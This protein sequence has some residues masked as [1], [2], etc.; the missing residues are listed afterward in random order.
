MVSQKPD[1]HQI[2]D[3]LKNLSSE[4]WIRRDE[5]RLWPR[6]LFHYTD[7]RNAV[8]ILNDGYLYS[9]KYV[10]ENEKLRVSSGSWDV[11]DRTDPYFKTCAR[12]YFRP[13]TP[14][15]F[16]VEGIRSNKTLSGAK[17]KDAHCPVMVFFLFDA[18]EV[19]SRVDCE[20][21]DGNLSS[22]IAK[23]FSNADDLRKLP[24]KIIYH[25]GSLDLTRSDRA[26]IIIRRNAEVI[27]KD[28][29]SLS[30]L[31]YIYCRSAAEKDTLLNLLSDDIRKTYQPK[32]VSTTRSLL[33]FREHTFLENVR[34]ASENAG[35]QF[36]PESRSP[37]PFR[38][39]LEVDY[40]NLVPSTLEDNKFVLKSSAP[41]GVKF[42]N[43]INAYTITLYLDG[44][45]AY[46][47]SFSERVI[48]F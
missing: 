14:T 2:G 24:W 22:P 10:E 27:V 17:F 37:G 29:L 18:A 8:S 42:K 19:L 32:V 9:R 23:L 16:H 7:L 45:L 15:Q 4:D 20:F 48:P 31:R 25:Q 46:S 39:L 21:S 40:G 44:Y 28:K 34:L 13:K 36:S 43:P 1:A 3:F 38:L 30:S 11:L 47:N 33:F 5:R 6:F 12:L 41:W 35:F 26:E